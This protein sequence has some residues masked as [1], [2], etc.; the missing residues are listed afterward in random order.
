MYPMGRTL[1]FREI[2]NE[3]QAPL[4]ITKIDEKLENITAITFDQPH[5]YMAFACRLF[6]DRSAYVFFYDLSQ[7]FRRFLHCIHEGNPTD[8][9][10]KSFIS[11]SFSSDASRIAVLTNPK[12]GCAKIYEWKKEIRAIS[13]CS[14]FDE[15]KK[16]AKSNDEMPKIS[17][18]SL[19]PNDKDQICLSGENHLRIW[20][21]SGG[22]LK[23]VIPAI[24][25]LDT[26][27][28]F[29]DHTWLDSIWLVAATDQGEIFFIY[30]GKECLIQAKAFGTTI[31]PI[32]CLVQYYG[33][34]IVAGESGTIGLWE[35][36]E[37]RENTYGNK[38]SPADLISYDRNVKIES[39]GKIVAMAIS[40]KDSNAQIAIGYRTNFLSLLKLTDILKAD[41]RKE[42]KIDRVF[43]DDGYH[44]GKTLEEPDP[45]RA[46]FS[47]MD[48]DIAIH[49]PLIVTSCKTDSTLRIWNYQTMQC[50]LVKCLT[51]QKTGAAPEPVRP[52]C[53]AFHPSGYLIAGGFDSQAIIWHLL[54]DELRPFYVFSNYKHV[55]RVRFSNSGH[56]IAI[57]QMLSTNKAVFIHNAYTMQRLHAIRLPLN[58]MLCDVVFSQDD[59]LVALCCTDGFLI[60]YNLQTQTETMNH[61]SK[62]CVYFGCQIISQNDVIAYGSDETR[63][64][65]IRHIVQ[66]D[67]VKN[68]KFPNGRIVSGQFLFNKNLMIGTEEGT[69]KLLEDPLNDQISLECNMHMGAVTKFMVTPDYRRAFSIGEDGVLFVYMLKVN[70]PNPEYDKKLDEI[71]PLTSI[72]ELSNVVL[73]EKIKLMK[74]KTN[75]EMLMNKVQDLDAERKLVEEHLIKQHQ[76]QM[77]EME[78]EK[79]AQIAELENRLA[80]IRTEL[81]KRE[82]HYTEIIRNMESKH[83]AA[84]VDLETIYKSKIEQ[85]HKAYMNMEQALKE[86]IQNLQEELSNRD[87]QRTK[88]LL[89]DHDKCSKDLDKFSKRLVEMKNAQTEAERKYNEKRKLQDEEHDRELDL[90]EASL[91]KEMADLKN[92]IHTKDEELNRNETRIKDLLTEKTDLQHKIKELA[93]FNEQLDHTV[94]KLNNDIE[95]AHKDRSEAIEEAKN[96]KSALVK[97]KSKYKN[98]IKECQTLTWAAKGLKDHIN[99]MQEENER[100][101]EKISEIEGEY[102]EY[103]EIMEKQKVAHEKQSIII[104][105]Q[106][107]TVARKENEIKGMENRFSELRKLIH[108]YKEKRKIDKHAYDDMFT[109]LYQAYVATADEKIDKPQEVVD[110]LDKQIKHLND[111]A[112]SIEYNTSLKIEQLEKM[113]KHLRDENS[114]LLRELNATHQKVKNSS[115]FQQSLEGKIKSLEHNLEL[116]KKLHAKAGAMSALTIKP[117]LERSMSEDK[118]GIYP[119]EEVKKVKT[120]VGSLYKGMVQN[121]TKIK[122]IESERVS[123]LNK[124]LQDANNRI[125][126]L[127]MEVMMLRE[128]GGKKKKPEKSMEKSAMEKDKS[129][130]DISSVNASGNE[131]TK[132]SE[133]IGNA[134]VSFLPTVRGVSKKPNPKQI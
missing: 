50:E 79:N 52:L 123:D 83:M 42:K 1:A 120:S 13:A 117:S 86:E 89:D 105:Q 2:S 132:D 37:S 129:E 122:T 77:S 97:A 134:S 109:E 126:Q 104:H 130:I 11:I 34:L 101:K 93:S 91:H 23:P 121:L 44:L 115:K 45:T 119:N 80:N 53:V 107:E 127:R 28:N 26:Q 35:K 99:P 111:K 10:E 116:T 102:A 110:E 73:I 60:V 31:E 38:K 36:K 69:I 131:Y 81:Q 15:L 55:V 118:M 22:I 124:Q 92:I 64:G 21:S 88:E 17:K 27:K 51:L 49:R 14:W 61:S 25:N 59:L 90:R 84:I 16:V 112:R 103:M 3:A 24:L 7:G 18:I 54:M 62:R 72:E 67:V 75:L 113:C 20:R 56:M 58:V 57:A 133:N 98:S 47:T 12:L 87:A 96:L 94:S 4:T 43:I 106:Q 8:I 78:H 71:I 63:K 32:S 100:L 65:I 125:F 39:R 30:E 6:N 70:T 108:K 29:T 41:R 85:E 48:M 9:D 76:Q 46:L 82:Q 95:K 33:G 74:D 66:D 5:A 68:V 128:G 40:G 19:D 114:N